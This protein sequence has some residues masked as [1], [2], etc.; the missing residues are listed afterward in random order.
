MKYTIGCRVID[1][2]GE[3]CDG[4]YVFGRHGFPYITNNVE[5]FTND[6]QSIYIIDGATDTQKYIQYLSRLY[7]YEFKNRAK[8]LNADVREF[9]FYPIKLT[10]K[11]FN[12]CTFERDTKWYPNKREHP[13]YRFEGCPYNVSICYVKK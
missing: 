6:G 1:R 5:K 8:K 3:V 10:D 7:R 12:G 4:L 13:K 9:R 2:N 11:R